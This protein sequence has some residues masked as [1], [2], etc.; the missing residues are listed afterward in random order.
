MGAADVT[1]RTRARARAE[2]ALA[3]GRMSRREF[4]RRLAALGVSGAAAGVLAE[5]VTQNTANQALRNARLADSYD[6]IVCGSGSAGSVVAGR[7][8]TATDARVLLLE[9]GG[10][11]DLPAILDLA[12]YQNLGQ[13]HMWDFHAEPEP[14][15]NGRTPALPMGRVLGGGSSVN[16]LVYARGHRADYDAWARLLGDP[17]WSYER[18]VDV[19]RAMENFR[20]P[21]HPR[22]RGRDGPLWCELPTDIHP[23]AA[24]LKQAAAEAGIPPVADVNAESMEGTA[25]V[26]HPNVIV[27]DGMRVSLARDYLYPALSRPNLT[28]LTNAEVER[29]TLEGDRA[30]GVVFTWKG[31]RHVVRA[32]GELVLSMGALKTPQI[33][34]LSGVGPEDALSSV[35]VTPRRVL[36]GVGENFQDYPLVAGCIWEYPRPTPPVASVSQCV[37]FDRVGGGDAQ[38]PDLMP[39][40]I[41]VPFASEIHG[42][43]FGLPEWGWTIAPGI[44]KP[45]SRGRLTLRSDRP[46]DAP[47]VHAGFLSHPDDRRVLRLGV[48]QA[49]ELGNSATMREFVRREVMP[50]PL[51]GRALDDFIVNGAATYYHMSGTCRMGRDPEAVV[52]SQL[53]VHGVRGLRIADTSVIPDIPRGNTMAPAAMIAEQLVRLLLERV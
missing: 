3:T 23:V 4:V 18:V 9:A 26:G 32:S 6:Y 31:R 40:Q 30:T 20:G 7:L 19:Y 33:L 38:A 16:A 11:D 35:G 29:I 27:R 17:R 52:D 8:A 22:L 21:E 24:A 2:A 10:V 25:C 28:V 41:Q 15:L 5:T 12:W 36:S 1:G 53:R 34:M 39:V 51:A 47:R 46:G 44:A 49:R 42:P 45:V 43:A 37:L 50:G 14:A 48:E 13:A